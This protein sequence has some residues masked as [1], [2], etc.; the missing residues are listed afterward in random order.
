LGGVQLVELHPNGRDAIVIANGD[1]WCVDILNRTAQQIL[2]A[3][4]SAF[5]V[6]SPS[7]WVFTRQGLALAR[8]GPDG[9]LWHTKRLS[10]DGFGQIRISGDRLYGVA[11]T[12]IEEQWVPFEVDLASGRSWGGGFSDRDIED[13][14]QIA[15]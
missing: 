11:S 2:P 14:E 1:L 13:W 7:G 4:D 6:E 15:R 3:I 8:L 5:S 9:I 10:L 12:G